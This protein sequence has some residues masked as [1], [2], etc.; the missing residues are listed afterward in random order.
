MIK[1]LAKE[2]IFE[3]YNS[4]EIETTNDYLFIVLIRIDND[5]YS[6]IFLLE[7][8]FYPLNQ[9]ITFFKDRNIKYKHE[10]IILRV[11]SKNLLKIIENISS[12]EDINSCNFYFT[13]KV[14]LDKEDDLVQ[15]INYLG[16]IQ[17]KYFSNFDY[18]ELKENNITYLVIKNSDLFYL[19]L[20]ESNIK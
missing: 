14:K 2:E 10:Q 13:K 6:Y 11:L 15:L 1:L 19:F 16:Q 17:E 12:L 18:F 8:T 4:E 5:L 3:I 7:K 9:I 20:F